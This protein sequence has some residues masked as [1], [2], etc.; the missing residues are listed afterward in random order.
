M[1]IHAPAKIN[2]FLEIGASERGFHKIIS[3]V[4]IINLY[5]LIEIEE[6]S[7]TKVVFS[8]ETGIPEDNTVTKS[9]AI[10]KSLFGIDRNVM[11]KIR[12]N[13][14]CGG[15]LGGGS[16]DAASVLKAL[17]KLWKIEVSAQRLM[18]IAA[19]I[20]KDVPLFIEGKRCIMRGFGEQISPA[21]GNRPL[22]YILAVPPFE[23]STA[24]VY[25]QFDARGLKGNLTEAEGKI[26]LLIDCIEN[27]DMKGARRLMRNG[28]EEAY[29]DLCGCSKEVM[30]SLQAVTGERVFVS[31]SGGTLFSVFHDIS[32]A[33]KCFRL[34]HVEGWNCYIAESATSS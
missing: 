28:L 2:L 30:D 6:S 1:K 21:A 22:A 33:E 11:V 19:G 20:G 15:G 18:E 24:E 32:E 14:P 29:F 8:P 5:D 34:L 31:G 26:K 23:V 17:I 7:Y 12:K 9:I 25:S 3:L 4:D 13:I 10:L 27:N 16:S